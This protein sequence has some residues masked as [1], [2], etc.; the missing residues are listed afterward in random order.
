MHTQMMKVRSEESP[1]PVPAE[2]K[3]VV[4]PPGGPG[5]RV[6]VAMALAKTTVLKAR[7]SVDI[8]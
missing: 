5:R 8:S 4:L 6:V 2:R 7:K 3:R 1:S